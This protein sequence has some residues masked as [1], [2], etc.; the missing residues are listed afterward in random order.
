MD[1]SS[2]AG[3]RSSAVQHSLESEMGVPDF[4]KEYL[5]R[6]GVLNQKGSR[7]IS[8]G[9]L[10]QMGSPEIPAEND[11]ENDRMPG[12]KLETPS[13]INPRVIPQR[14]NSERER[15]TWNV[16]IER[17][18]RAKDLTTHLELDIADDLEPDLEEFARL[19]RLGNFRAAKSF[20][21]D[22]LEYF[23]GNQYVFVQ[24]AQMLMEMGDYKTELYP[25]PD[26]EGTDSL[27]LNTN[28]NL[29]RV[30]NMLHVSD[31]NSFIDTGELAEFLEY[32]PPGFNS[33]DL[34]LGR[35]DSTEV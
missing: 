31:S 17:D 6:D 12:Q 11:S 19:S 27:I 26:L 8:S 25:S 21:R 10:N 9:A 14:E 5:I 16:A 22:N 1:D 18:L 33:S 34:P 30:F 20:F 32:L 28:W 13:A 15:S 2:F 3:P 24:Y 35:L 4:L 7:N 23:V 29:I